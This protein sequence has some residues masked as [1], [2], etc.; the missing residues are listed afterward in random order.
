MV[1]EDDPWSPSAMPDNIAA[2]LI[3]E[4][5]ECDFDII[6]SAQRKKAKSEYTQRP[7]ASTLQTPT[8][9]QCFY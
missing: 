7:S 4:D 9:A 8:Y 5:D 6:G 3:D 2:V 1:Y